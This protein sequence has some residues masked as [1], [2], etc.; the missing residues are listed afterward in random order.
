MF[1]FELSAGAIFA[2]GVGAGILTSALALVITAVIY[3]KK[4]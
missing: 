3:S 1:V 4:K 2:I